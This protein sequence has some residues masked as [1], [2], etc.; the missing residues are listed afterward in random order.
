MT[1]WDETVNNLWKNN[2]EQ[3]MIQIEVEH[4]TETNPKVRY[5]RGEY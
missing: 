5:S 2:R 4:Y 3:F 1:F